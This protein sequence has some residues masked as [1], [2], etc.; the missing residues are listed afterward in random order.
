L[1]GNVSLSAVTG[2]GTGTA[3]VLRNHNDEKVVF[4]VNFQAKASGPLKISV[5]GYPTVLSAEGLME[6]IARRDGELIIPDL[7]SRGFAFIQLGRDGQ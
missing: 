5:R 3:A 2:G 7:D 6:P 4:V 1:E